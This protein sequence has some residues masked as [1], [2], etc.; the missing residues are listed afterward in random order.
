[1]TAPEEFFVLETPAQLKAISDPFRQQL[2]GAFQ[3]PATAR[4]AA[5]K[6]RVPVGRLYHHIDQLAAAGLI[7]VVAERRRRGAVER[8]FQAVGRRFGLGP[9][10]LAG[11]DVAQARE[12]MAR[13]A[14][15]EMLAA[16]PKADAQQ[17]HIARTRVRL[18]P[19]ALAWFESRFGEFLRELESDDGIETDLLFFAAP[20][21]AD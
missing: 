12:A 21:E 1:V 14:L 2:V 18:T 3:A 20:R 9:G 17:L 16:I 11:A 7:K 19:E 10:A 6:L 13:G 4:E 8:T 15:D 5:E